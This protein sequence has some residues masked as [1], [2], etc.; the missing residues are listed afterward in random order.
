M[1]KRLVRLRKFKKK[2][3]F[4][5]MLAISSFLNLPLSVIEAR[6]D[7]I[8]RIKTLFKFFPKFIFTTTGHYYSET[9]KY[10]LIFSKI[11]REN[12]NSSAWR[13]ARL[14]KLECSQYGESRQFTF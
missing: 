7:Y 12:N 4:F 1:L 2:N 3:N 8:F 11:F 14:W 6:N 13:R 9:L 5:K 10:T